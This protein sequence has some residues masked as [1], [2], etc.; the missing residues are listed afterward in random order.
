MIR[1][2]VKVFLSRFARAVQPVLRHMSD[3][4]VHYCVVTAPILV[5]SICFGTDGAAA[6]TRTDS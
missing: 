2:H 6:R 1:I 3:L 4:L 5:V